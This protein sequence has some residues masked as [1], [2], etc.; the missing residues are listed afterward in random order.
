MFSDTAS[1]N[2]VCAI[3]SIFEGLGHVS[4]EHASAL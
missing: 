1:E 3:E 4:K 2:E